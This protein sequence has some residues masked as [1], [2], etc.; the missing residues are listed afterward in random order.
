[1][2]PCRAC[3]WGGAIVQTV[4]SVLGAGTDLGHIRRRREAAR[5]APASA[6]DAAADAAGARPMSYQSCGRI[7]ELSDD[8]AGR[9]A[10]GDLVACAGAGFGHH[11]GAVRPVVF[12]HVDVVEALG[13]GDHVGGV[14]VHDAEA[15]HGGLPARYRFFKRS[16]I[17][18]LISAIAWRA[19]F[20]PA[21]TS[22]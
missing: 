4:C 16:L 9:F 17:W 7:V 11:R 5:G 1:M 18:D 21:L 12:A 6:V 10:V 2:P 13:E 3:R 14:A 15:D 19:V 22:G 20:L 8:L